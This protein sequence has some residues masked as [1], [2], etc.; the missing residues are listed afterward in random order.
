MEGFMKFSAYLHMFGFTRNE[1][2]VIVTLSLSFLAGLGLQHL[3]TSNPRPGE[4][5][6][7]FNYAVSD[8]IFQSK[9]SRPLDTL[10]NSPADTNTIQTSSK[11]VKRGNAPHS[12]ININTATKNELMELP[13][14][15]ETYA[16]RIL[17]YRN[18]HGPFRSVDELENI[19]G[20]GKKKLEKIKPFA[21]VK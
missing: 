5:D 6:P 9:A 19:S 21:K 7:L 15:G 2:I 4:D 8:S 17:I 12:I 18:D 10:A 1:T 3:R 11:H 14:I 20:I 16:E 13:G